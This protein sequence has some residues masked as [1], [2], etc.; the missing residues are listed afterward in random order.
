M[1]LTRAEK[2]GINKMTKFL[3]KSILAVSLVLIM[4]SP[5]AAY[6]GV[7]GGRFVWCPAPCSIEVDGLLQGLGN[8][9]KGPNFTPTAFT[10]T[11]FNISGVGLCK[12]P[13]ANSFEGNG[14]PFSSV[15]VAVTGANAISPT[16]ITK[17]GKALAD[18][19]I[20]DQQITDALA[21]AGFNFTCQNSNWIKVVVVTQLEILGRQLSDPDPTIPF[22]TLTGPDEDLVIANC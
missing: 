18:I 16:Q 2:R 4:S 1:L 19:V 21:L 7:V 6:V 12:N 8:V 13:A 5:A 11:A 9:I 10:A 3:I 15:P 14:V 20:H 22:C 17:N